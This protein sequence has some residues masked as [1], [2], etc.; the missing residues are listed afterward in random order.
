VRFCGAAATVLPAA[1]A[2]P[3][4]T[5][6]MAAA[7]TS[8]APSCVVVP[9]LTEG[10]YFVDEKLNRADIPSDPSNGSVKDGA[11]LNIT[12]RVSQMNGSACAPLAGARVDV[13]H[14]DAAGVYS[15]ASDP[16]FNTQGQQFLR[17]YQVTAADG[18]AQFTTI[19]LG[20]YQGRAVHIHFKIRADPDSETGHKFTSQWFFDEAL[21]DQ[22][23][24][25]PPY[26]ATFDIGMQMS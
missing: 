7:T 11:P 9:A 1:T 21:T 14:C 13:W 23:H 15:D 2:A 12:V 17:G 6:E 5:V 26:A 3:A 25:Q 16:G 8:A 19:Y 20:W 18:T 22:V 4:A 10:P 24:A